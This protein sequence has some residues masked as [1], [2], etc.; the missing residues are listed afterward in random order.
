MIFFSL[1]SSWKVGKWGKCGASCGYSLKA[2]GVDC[3]D[4]AERPVDDSYCK[5]RMPKMVEQCFMGPC[6]PEWVAEPWTEVR[7]SFIL[8]SLRYHIAMQ[9]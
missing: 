8:P 9:T 4:E 5:G 7:T 6:P 3:I 2:R 1:F